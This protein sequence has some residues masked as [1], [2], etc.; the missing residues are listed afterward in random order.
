MSVPGPAMDDILGRST[1]R[2]KPQRVLACLLCQQRKVKCDRKHPCANC[3]KSRAQ[4]LPATQVPRQ[5]K[6]RFPERE[7]LDRLRRYEDIMRRNNIEFDPLHKE[8]S[9]RNYLKEEGVE[10]SDSDDELPKTKCVDRPSPATTT[11]S[12]K[13]QH[14][15][16]ILHAMSQEFRDPD[17]QSHSSDDDVREIHIQ[18][19][20]ETIKTND[21]HLLF[22][23]GKSCVDISTFHP[24]PIYI[25]KLWQ[26]YLDNVNPLLK[27]T[28]MPSV[29]G[30]IIEAASNVSNIE[31]PLEALMFSFYCVAVLSLEDSNCVTMFGSTKEAL[32]VGY[33]FG[34]QQAL[35][36]CQFL[37]TTDRE[38]LT[39]LFLY[40]VSI[41][42]VSKPHSISSVLG[43]AIRIA[44][45]MGID[46]ES[47][48]AKQTPLEA[49][50]CRR[51]WWALILFDGRVGEMAGAKMSS[52]TPIWDCKVVLN[53]AEAD[54]RTQMKEPPQAQSTFSDALFAVVR[55]EVANFVRYTKWHIDFSSP[56][57]LPVILENHRHPISEGSEMG[58]L[59]S[60]IEDKYL[61]LCDPEIPLHFMTIWSARALLAK[62]RLLE[63]YS[64]SS[65][66]PRAQADAAREAA[67]G[68][69]ITMLECDTKVS[70]SPLTVG[71]RWMIN[72]YYP[73]PAYVQIVQ[74]LK[75]Q[76]LS[77]LSERAW[78][79]MNNNYEAHHTIRS[80]HDGMFYKILAPVT[81]QAWAVR[82]ELSEK[83]GEPSA[84]PRLISHIRHIMQQNAPAPDTQQ[85]QVVLDMD[86]NAFP[87]SIPM[88]YDQNMFFGVGSQPAFSAA[89]APW[90]S[91][92][93][94]GMP[95]LSIDPNQLDW[96]SIDWNLGDAPH[97][98]GQWSQ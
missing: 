91:P 65:S 48:L 84:T 47:I 49:E 54:L 8:S 18:K 10:G 42:P 92:D 14:S 26:L 56:S 20:M 5:R 1:Q 13:V 16:N 35:L 67:F 97:V 11:G 53:V 38:C 78:E 61:K 86:M 79:A 95:P 60:M 44:Q 33:H 58:S 2:T 71:F 83:M 98:P 21:D 82:E 30:R 43:I 90:G 55:S 28:H 75:R 34:C 37:R 74:N 31:P 76:P 50:L 45:R 36:N 72:F 68:H 85:Q 88:A 77:P 7:L 93:M 40:L 89:P 12:E 57:L 4:C 73:F 19:A 27:V 64:R 81:L 87:M 46:K 25:F 23:S 96:S 39:A 32:L 22:G 9:D 15:K 94:L 29:Q 51:L 62:C 24:E 41:R 3:I 70:T 80:Q 17:N 59:V 52:L 69:A 66:M 63:H 6:R